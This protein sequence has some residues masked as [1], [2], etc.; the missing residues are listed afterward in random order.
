M[1]NEKYN[2]LVSFQYSFSGNIIPTA[3]NRVYY[4]F[5]AYHYE[6]T[7]KIKGKVIIEDEVF[8]LVNKEHPE[9]SILYKVSLLND[10]AILLLVEPPEIG[11]NV[12]TE[13]EQ[14]GLKKYYKN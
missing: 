10:C 9:H 6:N 2:A 7:P 13:D 4:F 12:I 14:N 1:F 11:K 3:T 5:E 8:I